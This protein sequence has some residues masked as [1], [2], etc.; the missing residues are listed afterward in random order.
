M[1]LFSRRPAQPE[2]VEDC[3]ECT[4]IGSGAMFSLSG[5][6]LWQ[7]RSLVNRVE[8]SHIRFLQALSATFAAFGVLRVIAYRNP[9][10]LQHVGTYLA[11]DSS[12]YV[13]EAAPKDVK[14]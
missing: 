6:M 10:W 5:Y 13:S 4:V 9:A 3:L 2:A 8:R 1:G 14:V 11:S 7:T 12:P